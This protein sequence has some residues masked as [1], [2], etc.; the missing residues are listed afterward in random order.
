[1]KLDNSTWLF[2]MLIG[3][4]WWVVTE[5]DTRIE[6][7]KENK[8][9]RQDN[10]NLSETI[11]KQSL[12]FNQFNQI[13]SVAYRNGIQADTK[14]QEKIIEYRTIL[15]KESV[16]DPLVPQP[17]ANGLYEYTNELRSSAMHTNTSD[18]N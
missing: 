11:S 3:L 14:A 7:Q 2:L 4:G 13:A 6:V 15:K 10:N 18:I 17:I 8:Q 5:H 1:M 16:C 12:Q 9:L